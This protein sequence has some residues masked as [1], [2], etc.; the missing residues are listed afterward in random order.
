MIARGDNDTATVWRVDQG[1][2]EGCRY[3]RKLRPDLWVLSE[4][5]SR[6]IAHSTVGIF[7]LRCYFNLS[8][9]GR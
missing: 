2:R 5:P 3:Y 7:Q 4:P 8:T 9:A 6:A 1:Y